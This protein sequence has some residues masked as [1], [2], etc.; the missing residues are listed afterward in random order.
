MHRFGTVA[1]DAEISAAEAEIDNAAKASHIATVKAT[2]PDGTC[3][4]APNVSLPPLA[5][6]GSLAAAMESA[7][8]RLAQA[9]EKLA[10]LHTQK[11]QQAVSEKERAEAADKA[12]KAQAAAQ[13]V[14]Q[15]AT[16]SKQAAQQVQQAKASGDP[17]AAQQ[18]AQA[19][20]QAKKS[21]A[22]AAE[23]AQAATGKWSL[24]QKLLLVGA[25]GGTLAASYFMF[26]PKN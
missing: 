20:K 18:A 14:K 4:V 3:I 26:R 13:Q 10:A 15:A 25:I 12:A 1:L 24:Q 2:V 19:V 17:A 22:A 11:A 6:N 23:T 9:G 21:S 5:C 7:Q 8:I 16:Q